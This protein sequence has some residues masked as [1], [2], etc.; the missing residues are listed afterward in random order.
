MTG[1]K[2]LTLDIETAP[3]VVDVW[4]L[5]NQNIGLNQVHS[6]TRMISFAAKW[7]G[8]PK[9]LFHSE[10]HDGFEQMV[11]AAHD[12]VNEADAL[13]GWNSARFDHT[14]M[15][16]EFL[17]A[18]LEPPSPV[19]Q[20][21]LMRTA[22][23]E[24]RFTSNK[25]EHV[26]R[27]LGLAGKVQHQGHTLWRDCLDPGV[28]AAVKAAAWAKMRKYNIGDVVL[29]EQVYDLLRPWVSNHPHLGLF[30]TEGD[31]TCQRCGSNELLKR[32]FAYTTLSSYQRYRCGGCGS[33]SRG[34]QALVTK[35]IRAVQ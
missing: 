24:F 21:D 9:V 31:E 20:I 2:V 34:G 28:D 32:G 33:W 10:Y 22:K 14:H 35:K 6:V 30:D 7:H 18:G 4:G 13:V 27:Q 17:L 26:S 19:I 23:R 16:R 25:L 12:L 29:T 1:P 3:N 15:R 11:A 8:K 5:F